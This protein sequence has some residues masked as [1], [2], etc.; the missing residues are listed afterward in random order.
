MRISDWSSDVCSSDLS[1][2][3][4]ALP[5]PRPGDDWG[6]SDRNVSDGQAGTPGLFNA[7]GTPKL[8]SGDG[9]VG[10][11]LPPGTITADFEKIERHGPWRRRQPYDYTPPAFQRVWVPDEQ[12]QPTWDTRLI[13]DVERR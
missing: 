8:A 9:K 3:P 2:R 11:G 10:G 4:G 13:K 12:L 6:L 1:P 7:D 5:S